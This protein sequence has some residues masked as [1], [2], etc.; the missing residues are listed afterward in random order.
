VPAAD[1]VGGITG[2]R[3]G[4]ALLLVGHAPNLP[5]ATALGCVAFLAARADARRGSGRGR[6]DHDDGAFVRV[7]QALDEVRGRVGR[8]RFEK[9]EVRGL[10][11]ARVVLQPH[12]ASQSGRDYRSHSPP[13]TGQP[14]GGAHHGLAGMI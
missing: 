6:A 13:H 7:D 14:V 10:A 8:R 4:C 12:P 5:E 2:G 11:R 3:A 9:C 1:A